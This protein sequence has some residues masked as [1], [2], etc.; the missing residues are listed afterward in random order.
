VRSYT[1]LN[2]LRHRLV[3]LAK[4]LEGRFGAGSLTAVTE[5]Q[6]HDLFAAM[7]NGHIRKKGGGAYRSTGDYVKV[8]R[9][10]WHWHIKTQRK[11]SVTVE[12]IFL[13]LDDATEKPPWVYLSKEDVQHLCSHAKHH[14][15]ILIMFLFDTGI[16]SPTELV[17]VNAEHLS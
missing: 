2:T 15:R 17:N 13:D 16:R 14:Y 4:T 5:T 3:F 10:F 8:F 6:A 12:D 7:R 9:A 11:Q 1:R